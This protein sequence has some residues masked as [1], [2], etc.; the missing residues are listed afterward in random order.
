MN[1]MNEESLWESQRRPQWRIPF[2][3]L[4][5]W[6]KELASAEDYNGDYKAALNDLIEA[7]KEKGYAIEK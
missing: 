4:Q 1:E 2:K 3:K 6:A 7:L 5:K